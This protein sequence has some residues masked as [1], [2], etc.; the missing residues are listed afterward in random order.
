MAK[1]TTTSPLSLWIRQTQ[2]LYERRSA[3][4]T[5]A[6]CQKRSCK[7]CR[8]SGRS[9]VLINSV[10][11]HWRCRY[12]R[13]DP[14]TQSTAQ[15]H[16]VPALPPLPATCQLQRPSS[17]N[18]W[19]SWTILPQRHRLDCGC[20]SIENPFRYGCTRRS[21][22]MRQVRPCSYHH[23]DPGNSANPIPVSIYGSL[24]LDDVVA[25]RNGDVRYEFYHPSVLYDYIR[26]QYID[27]YELSVI[28]QVLISTLNKIWH[29]RYV[30]GTVD[31]GTAVKSPYACCNRV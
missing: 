16:W 28:R 7:S 17:W 13:H 2:S 30:N 23:D 8:S 3:D 24:L 26:R 29:K 31:V 10:E 25:I 18:G 6:S 1:F 5:S 4:R 11:M 14:A 27:P 15:R 12:T 9:G 20:C 22:V 19:G 21:A